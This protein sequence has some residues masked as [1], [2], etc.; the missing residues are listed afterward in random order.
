MITYISYFRD[1]AEK[2]KIASKNTNLEKER[3]LDLIPDKSKCIVYGP[4]LQAGNEAGNETY[5]TI[6]VR[7]SKNNII[8]QGGHNI[9]V[10]I[11]GP[12]SQSKFLAKDN[13]NGLY[14]VT[15][16][17][18]EDGNYVIE[19][20]LNKEAIGESPV[21]ISVKPGQKAMGSKPKPHW[22]CQDLNTKKWIPYSDEDSDMLEDQ[23]FRFGGGTVVIR[24]LKI[25]ISKREEVNTQKK[26]IIHHIARP[27][28]RGTWYWQE[29]DN[30]WIPYDEA[31]AATLEKAIQNNEFN[32]NVNISDGKKVRYVTQFTDGTFRQFRPI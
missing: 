18:D 17:P 19:V 29:D 20:N 3:L 30:S 25:D 7:N 10:R 15:F 27:I 8:P 31:T 24:E 22:F 11:T 4:A 16:T 2:L 21:H 1:A 13:S 28:L 9:D 14:F 23:F 32:K 26:H 12:H 5:F 6:E